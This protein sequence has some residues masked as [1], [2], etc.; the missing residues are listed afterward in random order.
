MSRSVFAGKFRREGAS[1]MA[2]RKLRS[3][4]PNSDIDERTRRLVP[5]HLGILA[6]PNR[7]LE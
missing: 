7:I 2:V 1:T 3:L 4:H 5:S 6:E